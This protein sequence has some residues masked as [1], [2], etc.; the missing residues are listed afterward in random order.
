MNKLPESK[1]SWNS[2]PAQ[3]DNNIARTPD[4]AHLCL[5]SPTPYS[6]LQETTSMAFPAIT[7]CIAS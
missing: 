1:H 2:G 3:Q 7:S 5:P 4:T 6:Q